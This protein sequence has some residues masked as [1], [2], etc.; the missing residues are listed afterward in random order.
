MRLNIGDSLPSGGEA[1]ASLSSSVA[2]SLRADFFHSSDAPKLASVGDAQ[3]T[4][5]DVPASS[6]AGAIEIPA[7][8]MQALDSAAPVRF[9]SAGE[10]QAAN[11]QPDYFLTVDGKL[12][13]NEKAQPS[14]DGS[15]NIEIQSSKPEHNK[16]LHDAIMHQSEMQKEAAKDMIRLFQKNNPGK[17]VPGWMNDLAN[18]KP[19]LPAFVPFEP[20][21]N[22]PVT[23]PPENG[24]VNR[25]TSGLPGF[26]GNG[27]FDGGG[28]YRGNGGAGDGT[29][30]TGGSDRG[31]P[32]GPGETVKAKEI[33][34]YMTQKHQLP[35]HIAS[36]ILG[37]MMTE[38]NLRTDAYNPREGAIGLIQWLGS[39]RQGLE[40]F[41]AN[42]GK[43]VTDWRV[44]VDFMMHEL[45]TSE[46]GSWA[47]LQHAQ[48]P[49]EAAAIFDKYYERS[50]GHARGQRMANAEN[51][52]RTIA[53][54]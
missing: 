42:E 36:G 43:P 11:R 10:N 33:F 21:P 3:P 31:K 52:H 22:R 38:S 27:G 4:I 19:N 41:A 16:S 28:N 45:K 12:V 8:I 54:A 15:I 40:N 26:A 29:L 44:Q 49:G 18:A 35:P 24:F 6:P 30:W 9:S 46:S 20:A 5:S 1:T 13:K 32:M 48:T 50:S 7:P 14:P 37:N 53:T 47:R 17:P 2:D 34:D 23:P 39:R 25:G 51:I